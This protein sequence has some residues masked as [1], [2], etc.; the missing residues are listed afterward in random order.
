MTL[1]INNYLIH[2]F[3]RS[4]DA[5]RGYNWRGSRRTLAALSPSPVEKIWYKKAQRRVVNRVPQ[6]HPARAGGG[7]EGDVG[8]APRPDLAGD[9]G[10]QKGPRAG[11]HRHGDGGAEGSAPRSPGEAARVLRILGRPN[12]LVVA[13][14]PV[15]VVTEGF[16]LPGPS[17]PNRTQ[18]EVPLPLPSTRLFL[19]SKFYIIKIDSCFL[20]LHTV[21]SS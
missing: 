6:A 8:G 16:S 1:I 10:P 21:L 13:E 12:I 20:G 3:L 17:P 2:Q 7:E 15:P 19:V 14:A 18:R 4:S 9:R 11:A 5:A